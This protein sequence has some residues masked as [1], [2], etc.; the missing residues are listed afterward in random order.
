MYL[1]YIYFHS[2]SKVML[3]NE[4]ALN[5]V[6]SSLCITIQCSHNKSD[7]KSMLINVKNKVSETSLANHY[8]KVQLIAQVETKLFP[9]KPANFLIR[10]C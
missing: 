7:F 10:A 5:L 6:Y 1:P 2:E 9:Y 8:N 3:D 4:S